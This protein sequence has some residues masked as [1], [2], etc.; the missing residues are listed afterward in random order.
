MVDV[1]QLSVLKNGKEVAKKEVSVRSICDEKLAQ[2]GIPENQVTLYQSVLQYG[3]YAQLQFGAHETDLPGEEGVPGIAAVSPDYGNINNPDTLKKY[4]KDVKFQLDL[5]EA[6]RIIVTITPEAG[7][8][9]EDYT[10]EVTGKDA[11][12]PVVT[13]T[14]SGNTIRL[15]IGGIDS[16][17]MDNRFDVKISAKD[18]TTATWT[19]SVLNCAYDFQQRNIAV[20]LVGALNKYYQS[21]LAVFGG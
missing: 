19:R 2:G 15:V 14:V 8:S 1:L 9:A 7:Y 20:D 5:A 3:R 6:V 21:A 11:T 12:V 13:K 18:G 4:I 10:V 17:R 16:D